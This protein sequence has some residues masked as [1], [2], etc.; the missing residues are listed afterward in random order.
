MMFWSTS[1][2]GRA[3]EVIASVSALTECVEACEW[4]GGTLYLLTWQIIAWVRRLVQSSRQYSLSHLSAYTY[5]VL[6]VL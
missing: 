3:Y 1:N 4:L 6:G 5:S 2:Q